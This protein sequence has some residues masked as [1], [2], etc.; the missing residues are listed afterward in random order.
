MCRSALLGAVPTGDP[1]RESEA[2]LPGWASTQAVSCRRRGPLFIVRCLSSDD[3]PF[4]TVGESPRPVILTESPRHVYRDGHRLKRPRIGVRSREVLTQRDRRVD[5]SV[6]GSHLLHPPVR[7]WGRQQVEELRIGGIHCQTA[8][9]SSRG[10]QRPPSARLASIVR[11]ARA[12]GRS[13]NTDT[14]RSPRRFR[15]PS[16]PRTLEHDMTPFEKGSGTVLQFCSRFICHC[17]QR[18]EIQDRP[19][20][21]ASQV[22]GRFS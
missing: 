4:G 20:T 8:T 22:N 16:G 12:S 6:V 13:P 7:P 10:S 9:T 3:G 21:T 1:H 14:E 19:P 11:T 5:C 15:R 2:R 17:P 18:T